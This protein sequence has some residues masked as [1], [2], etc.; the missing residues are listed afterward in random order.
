MDIKEV[1]ALLPWSRDSVLAAI[2]DGVRL[3]KSGTKLKL[4]AEW[5]GSTLQVSEARLR[6]FLD[7]F[8]D[9]EPGRWPPVSVRPEL[10]VEAEHKGGHL[11]GGSP[12]PVLPHSWGSELRHH[13][14]PHVL[15][16][17]G[18]SDSALHLK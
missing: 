1:T 2:E 9:E 5:H 6:E 16:V 4:H 17:C 12:A 15:A 8:E 3:P 10:R 18:D 13:D 7:A 14:P 11:P